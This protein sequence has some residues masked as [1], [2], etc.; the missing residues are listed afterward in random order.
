[1]Q[2]FRP[3]PRP[4]ESLALGLGA[5]SEQVIHARFIAITVIRFVAKP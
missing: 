3:S 5:W 2:R 4:Y 1:M